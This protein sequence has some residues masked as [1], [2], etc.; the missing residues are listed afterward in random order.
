MRPR[1]AD[2][3]V[4]IRILTGLPAPYWYSPLAPARLV[5]TAGFAAKT[6]MKA[7]AAAVREMGSA[8][9]ATARAVFGG[10]GG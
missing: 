6:I 1:D 5:D 4:S 3:T 7:G 9:G 10:N 2:A 8:V